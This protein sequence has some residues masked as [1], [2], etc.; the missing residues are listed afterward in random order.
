L[1]LASSFMDSVSTVRR[2]SAKVA[3]C[4]V[5]RANLGNDKQCTTNK[6]RSCLLYDYKNF[7]LLLPC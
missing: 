3:S 5:S 4:Y 1:R 6:D 2:K 7:D